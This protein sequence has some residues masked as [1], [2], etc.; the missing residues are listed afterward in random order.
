[1]E[2]IHKVQQN[3]QKCLLDISTI[4]F[5][6][7]REDIKAIRIQNKENNIL[8]IIL[9]LPLQGLKTATNYTLGL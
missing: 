3:L 6:E 5:I 8:K 4:T 7:I 1:M 2:V 9:D